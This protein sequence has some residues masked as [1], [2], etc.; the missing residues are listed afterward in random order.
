MKKQKNIIH[1]IGEPPKDEPETVKDKWKYLVSIIDYKLIPAYRES[2][3]NLA[4]SL[5]ALDDIESAIYDNHRIVI[6]N[7]LEGKYSEPAAYS[8]EHHRVKVQQ[9]CLELLKEFN[10]TPNSRRKNIRLTVAKPIDIDADIDAD[11]TDGHIK[12]SRVG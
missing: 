7:S 11:I 3:L 2:F 9:Q 12:I 6:I 4:R 10:L 5:C 8:L 1:T